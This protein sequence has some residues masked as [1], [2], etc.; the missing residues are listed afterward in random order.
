MS[1]HKK[2]FEIEADICLYRH[3]SIHPPLFGHFEFKMISK[4]MMS[5]VLFAHLN[6]YD[7]ARGSKSKKLTYHTRM[8]IEA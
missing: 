4:Y 6:H 2:T 3:M 8:E 1:L 5:L 7:I